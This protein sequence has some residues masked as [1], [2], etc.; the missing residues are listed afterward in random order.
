MFDILRYRWISLT[1]SCTILISAAVLSIYRINT[2]GY[3][4]SYSVDFTGGTQVLFKF[5]K[6]I[7]ASG[8]QN[9]LVQQWPDATIRKFDEDEYLVR[10]IEFA[11]NPLG[12]SGCW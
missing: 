5:D 2:R 6:P 10:V 1:V 12:R 3:A 7:D 4:F 9:G 8:I 11:R